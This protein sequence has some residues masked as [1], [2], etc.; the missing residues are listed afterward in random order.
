ML[1]RGLFLAVPVCLGVSAQGHAAERLP[2]QVGIDNQS[3]ATV[4][5]IYVSPAESGAWGGNRLVSTLSPGVFASVRFTGPCAANLRVILDDGTERTRHDVDLC[6]GSD[7]TLDADGLQ[8]GRGGNDVMPQPR[9]R[10]PVAT[11]APSPAAP[12]GPARNGSGAS[13]G[14]PAEHWDGHFLTHRY[15]GL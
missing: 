8:V 15:G 13:A 12:S 14:T 9:A 7:F 5:E 11:A 3:Q 2:H 1:T 4:R 10:A 6:T